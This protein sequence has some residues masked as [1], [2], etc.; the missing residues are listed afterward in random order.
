MMRINQ[1][2][3]LVQELSTLIFTILS[4]P[5]AGQVGLGVGSWTITLTNAGLIPGEFD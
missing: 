1:F 5:Y 2:R 3:C 4:G